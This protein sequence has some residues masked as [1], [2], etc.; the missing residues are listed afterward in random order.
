MDVSELS[1]IDS[2]GIYA[3]VLLAKEED[4][5]GPLVLRGASPEVMR[6]FELMKVG[7]NANLEFRSASSDGG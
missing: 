4:G 5:N 6:V 7:E 3:L 2:S 1:F